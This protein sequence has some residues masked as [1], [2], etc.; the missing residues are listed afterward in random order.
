MFTEIKHPFAHLSK[1]RNTVVFFVH[2]FIRDEYPK[3]KRIASWDD[4][5]GNYPRWSIA[6]HTKE[7]AIERVTE[8]VEEEDWE[9][10]ETTEDI[11]QKLVR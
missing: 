11:L 9:L 10:Y 6:T 7:D 2:D 8:M 3:D 4:I 1:D 5:A